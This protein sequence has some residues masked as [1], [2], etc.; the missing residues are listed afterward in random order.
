MLLDLM[1]LPDAG[2][3]DTQYLVGNSVSLGGTWIGVRVPRGASLLYLTIQGAG[4]NGGSG[5]TRTA[6][7]AGGGG[8]GGGTGGLAR[9]IAPVSLL[10]DE[11]W[12]S[13]GVAGVSSM[14]SFDG[15]LFGS[16]VAVNAGGSGGNG[17]GTAAGAVGSAA[18]A[19][20]I[21]TGIMSG[22]ITCV[23]LAGVAGAAGGAV[24]GAIGG[25]GSP[26]QGPL[27]YGGAGGAGCTT[28]DYDGGRVYAND[29]TF[30]AVPG[31]VAPGG[32]GTPGTILRGFWR[33]G[34]SGGASNNSGQAGNGGDGVIP[35]NGGAGG[36]AGATG[37]AGG[38]GA[39]AAAWLTWL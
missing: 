18:A 30:P 10:P 19:P 23:M 7:S 14:F 34:A 2:R 13:L 31:G 26:Q 20:S 39:P 17:S 4:G 5:H 25:G 28:T 16:V 22:V 1:H 33:R 36:G 21:T 29:P 15:S 35:G 24:T 9:I 38:V 12:F 3:G 8:G 6:G 11:L 27:A 37:G 32:N